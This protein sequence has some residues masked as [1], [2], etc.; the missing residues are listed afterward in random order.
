[1]QKQQVF[2]GTNQPLSV[3]KHAM[4]LLIDRGFTIQSFAFDQGDG[5]IIVNA[6][7]FTDQALS[8]SIRELL[9]SSESSSEA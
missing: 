9:E 8:D 7:N 3:Y 5:L 4:E 6:A 2:M 1:M